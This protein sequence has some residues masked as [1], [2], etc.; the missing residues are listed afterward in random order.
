[1]RNF[2]RLQLWVIDESGKGYWTDF[3]VDVSKI[4]AWYIPPD[5]DGI[6]GPSINIYMGSDAFGVKQE[7]HI[8]D[9]LLQNCFP[10]G[11]G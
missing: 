1:M 3:Y 5:D 4:T 7:A 6:G 2:Y 9:Y 11:K 10:D 8:K